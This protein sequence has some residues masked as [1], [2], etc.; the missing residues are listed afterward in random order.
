MTDLHQSAASPLRSLLPIRALAVTLEFT[1]EAGFSFFHQA[2]VYAF[3]GQLLDPTEKLDKRLAVDA[4]ESGHLH[5]SSGDRYR[6]AVYALAGGEHLLAR[7]IGRLRDLPDVA[8]VRDLKAP[9][10]NNVRLLA[11]QDLFTDEPIQAV[12]G[13]TLFDNDRLEGEAALWSAAPHVR[14]RW[15]SPVRML[16]DTEAR[17]E[18]KGEVRFCRDLSDIG[19]GLLLRRLYDA[20]TDLARRRGAKTVARSEPPALPGMGGHLFWV[21]SDY[22]DAKGRSHP[23]GGMS[24]E[25]IL[26]PGRDLPEDWWRLLVLGQYPGVGQMRAF[27]MGRYVLEAPQDLLH[28]SRIVAARADVILPSLDRL[29]ERA[30]EKVEELD[31]FVHGILLVRQVS[32]ASLSLLSY[33]T[34][35]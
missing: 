19:E 12:E 6:F 9:L 17:R 26:G 28:Q 16:K 22:R 7:L 31:L 27:G 3:V 13:L 18:A 1:A 25:I 8:P 33:F 24:G 5:Y 23:I 21:D 32:V 34:Q 2:A 29:V 30:G 20:L 35:K 4:P 10:R 15:L 14:L 11:L